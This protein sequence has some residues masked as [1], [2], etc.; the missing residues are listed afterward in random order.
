MEYEQIEMVFGRFRC[1]SKLDLWIILSDIRTRA[2]PSVPL[3]GLDLE[4]MSEA[5]RTFASP[6][7]KALLD[8]RGVDMIYVEEDNK[9]IRHMVVVVDGEHTPFS[10]TTLVGYKP[11]KQ[12][13]AMRKNLLQ[14]M[15]RKPYEIIDTTSP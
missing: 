10:I 4:L 7:K 1:K 2:E 8:G 12:H 13:I 5:L 3:A 15:K 6:N 11:D 14:V 9:K